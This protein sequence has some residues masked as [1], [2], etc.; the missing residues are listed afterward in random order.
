MSVETNAE[1]PKKV[2]VDGDSAEQHPLEEQIEAEQWERRK[3]ASARS[4]LPIKVGKC[5][6]PG[7]V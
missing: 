1:K 4:G 7:A 6:P 2:V 3:A 5:R